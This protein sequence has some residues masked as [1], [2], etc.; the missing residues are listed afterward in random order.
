MEEEIV[1][2]SD[3]FKIL[4][5][6]VRLCIL[7]NLFLNGEKKVGELQHCANSSQSFVSQQLAKLKAQ[8]IITSKKVGN[9]VYYSLVDT[10]II[11]IIKSVDCFKK[12]CDK[13]EK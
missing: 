1:Q 8:N 6:E 2:M 13:N 12:E 7:V 11:E 10:K 4:S 5:N 9:E 3:L